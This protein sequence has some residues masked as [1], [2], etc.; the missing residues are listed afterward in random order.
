[1]RLY[2]EFFNLLSF[3]TQLFTS[4]GIG[5]IGNRQKKYSNALLCRVHASLQEICNVIPEFGVL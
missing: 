3:F 1:M 4:S 5:G 2:K